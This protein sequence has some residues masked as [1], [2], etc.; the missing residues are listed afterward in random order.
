[1]S[2]N[3]YKE[4]SQTLIELKDEPFGGKSHGSY[5][6]SRDFLNELYNRKCNRK[7]LKHAG[8]RAIINEASAKGHTIIDLTDRKFAIIDTYELRSK[9]RKGR[10]SEL[11]EIVETIEAWD[12][13][14]DDYE[15]EKDDD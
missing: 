11:S 15:E 12:E 1:M 5:Q 13:F 8:I 4:I 9:F 3:I 10:D 2:I 14:D 7:F 6:F